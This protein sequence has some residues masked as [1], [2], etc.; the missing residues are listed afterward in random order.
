[1]QGIDNSEVHYQFEKPKGIGNSTTLPIDIIEISKL[2]EILLTLTE[3]VT[4]RLRSY[5]LLAK[6]V[7]VQLRTKDFEDKSHQKK[8][9]E[10]TS[11]TKDIYMQA[12][13][14]LRE[15][16]IPGT[17]IR[18]IGI[19]VDNLIDKEEVQLSLIWNKRKA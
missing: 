10:P 7:N 8:L 14:L 12:K 17:S 11:N 9:L 16:Y 6:V 15:M 3:H 1:M 4:Y 18:L 5:D 13:E 19:R 2:E